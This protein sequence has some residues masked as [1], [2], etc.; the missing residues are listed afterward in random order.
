MTSF[1]FKKLLPDTLV[2]VGFIILAI[3]FCYPAMQ[4]K[5]LEAGDNI[6]WKGMSEEGRA[7]HEKTGENVLWSN[8]MFGGMPTYTHYI[9]ESNNFVSK[10][11]EVI[12]GALTKPT[13]FFF[14]AML[15]FYLLMAALSIDRWI[16]VIGAIAFAFSTYNPVI[17]GA[18]HDT[19]MLSIAYMP[20]VLGGVLLLYRSQWAK[21]AALL[22]VSLSLMVSNAHYQ[23]MYYDMILIAFA[24]LGMLIMAI[25]EGKIKQWF[26]ASV[27]SGIIAL[28]SMGV[29][30]P[31]I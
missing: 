6:S 18:G 21:G 7:Y 26:L 16:G 19:K 5:V 15:S 13:Y 31:L 14:I 10:I 23:I 8:S 28:V 12:V 9:A 2:I 11:Q 30:G 27:I 29:S 25:K 3:I 4:G 17:I 1:D 22:A 20:A 24:V